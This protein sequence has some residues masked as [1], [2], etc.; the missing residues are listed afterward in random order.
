MKR[1]VWSGKSREKEER[2]TLLLT[3][4]S[5]SL[6]STYNS[7]NEVVTVKCH[8]GAW[9]SDDVP[10]FILH[11]CSKMFDYSCLLSHLAH[12]EGTSKVTTTFN[13]QIE[14]IIIIIVH[15]SVVKVQHA[16]E[17]DLQV[18]SIFLRNIA[19]INLGNIQDFVRRWK[20]KSV[21]D[22]DAS[23]KLYKT[24]LKIVIAKWNHFLNYQNFKEGALS[25]WIH[26][27][28]VLEPAGHYCGH[29]SETVGYN[30]S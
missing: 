6:F 13:V 15:I 21:S 12:N 2:Q 22:P 26:L 23:C 1:S 4:R 10:Q 24:I 20:C 29:W 18:I 28:I 17:K 14:Y 9:N 25:E 16:T 7:G 30:S 8:Y 3:E 27:S 11:S 5:P 19:I